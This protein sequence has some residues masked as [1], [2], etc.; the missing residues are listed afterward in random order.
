MKNTICFSP[1]RSPQRNPESWVQTVLFLCRR[2]QGQYSSPAPNPQVANQSRDSE[3]MKSY[4]PN[5]GY[6]PHWGSKTGLV[7]TKKT[8]HD[9][10]LLPY[11]HAGGPQLD[12]KT[13]SHSQRW[14][15]LGSTSIVGL[16][17]PELHLYPHF[18]CCTVLGPRAWAAQGPSTTDPSSNHYSLF[19]THR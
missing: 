16:G 8:P 6:N 2:E 7:F 13:W 11:L 3:R 12:L 18:L 1:V 19:T 14:L 15:V 4:K 17:T 5:R 9:Q 10:V